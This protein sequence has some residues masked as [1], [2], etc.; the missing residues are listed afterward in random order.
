MESFDK[1][2]KNW[3]CY[4]LEDPRYWDDGPDEDE[5][6]EPDPEPDYDE[7]CLPRFYDGR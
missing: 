2:H 5:E 4:H 3:E 7:G 1:M 6:Y